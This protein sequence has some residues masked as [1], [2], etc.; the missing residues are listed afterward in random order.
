MSSTIWGW[1]GEV[2]AI[3]LAALVVAPRY[4]IFCGICDLWLM[5]QAPCHRVLGV[6]EDRVVQLGA[7]QGM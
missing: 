4:T 3:D 2:A 6:A 7:Q 5:H 1:L